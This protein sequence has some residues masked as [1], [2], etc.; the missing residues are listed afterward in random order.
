M[1]RQG[2]DGFGCSN[3][4]VVKISPVQKATE[5]SDP[6]RERDLWLVYRA[7][8]LCSEKARKRSLA[9]DHR[10]L[11]LCKNFARDLD[12]RSD[13]KLSHGQRTA[14]MRIL[15]LKELPPLPEAPPSKP[16]L[17]LKPPTKIR[18]GDP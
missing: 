4:G 6:E 1:S 11:R 16:R 8:A 7:I 15:D 2:G 3:G 5:L 12:R 17:P 14:L 13:S 10:I 9:S 18:F